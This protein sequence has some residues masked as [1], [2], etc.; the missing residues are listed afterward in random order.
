MENRIAKKYLQVNLYRSPFFAILI[1]L[2]GISCA[3]PPSKT[4]DNKHPN[5][6][7][8]AVDDLRPELNVYAKDWMITPNIDKLASEGS[9]FLNHFVNV[10]TCGASRYS[11][12]TGRYPTTKA[13]LS[14]NIFEIQTAGKVAGAEPESMIELFRRNGYYTVGIGKISHSPDGMI[15]GY[16]EKVSSKKELP[17]S[18]NE[19]LF[20]AGKWGTGWNAFFGYASGENRQSLNNRAKPYES[21]D[22]KDEDYPDGL[23][24]TLAVS[25]IKQLK[26][27]GK[28][29]F[30]AVGFFKPHLPFNAPKKYW[31]L[32]DE[33]KIPLSAAKEIPSGINNTSLQ[34]SAE[35]NQYKGGEEKPSLSNPV[36]DDYAQKLRHA[37]FASV[38]YVDAQIGKVLD[39][40]KEVGLDKHTIVVLWGDHGW[41]LGDQRVWGKHTLSEYSL[42]SPLIIK[43]PDR[44]NPRSRVEAIVQSVDIYPTLLELANIKS[45]TNLDGQS[46]VKI[47]KDAHHPKKNIAFAYFNN[48]IT[49]RTERY[50]ITKYFRKEQTVIELYDYLND[51][52]EQ[53]NIAGHYKKMTDS[54]L[55]IL[56]KGNTGLYNK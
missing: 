28:P 11:M 38:S 6:L 49:M 36:S 17:N 43:S 8:I 19:F 27:K 1:L 15:Y 9:L 24:A 29:F 5:V 50:R 47:T 14:N 54:L 23:I 3:N 7:F 31:D 52:F 16:R 13:A 42:K 45:Q 34:N 4:V 30:L 12:L 44:M 56:E 33:T 18:W 39:A 40:L 46:L 32:Y 22:V 25:Q 21:A 55:Q 26:Q 2:L 10:P 48:G 37:Y 41:H 51:P 35:F 53:Q 20:E